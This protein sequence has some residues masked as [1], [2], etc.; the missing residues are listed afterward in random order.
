MSKRTNYNSIREW[1][2]SMCAI[3]VFV[4]IGLIIN[5]KDSDFIP[6]NAHLSANYI[7]TTKG[8]ENQEQIRFIDTLHN[9]ITNETIQ[10]NPYH[11]R[12]VKLLLQELRTRN[13]TKWNSQQ[14]DHRFH[15]QYKFC[16]NSTRSHKLVVIR[17]KSLD[18]HLYYDSNIT[19]KI[20]GYSRNYVTCLKQ[21]FAKYGKQIPNIDVMVQTTDFNSKEYIFDY[22]QFPC[23]I[24]KGAYNHETSNIALHTIPISI[25]KTF[26]SDK[27]LFTEYHDTLN[28]KNK[29]NSAVFRGSPFFGL[30]GMRDRVVF[31]VNNNLS[32]NESEYFDAKLVNYPNSR[33]AKTPRFCGDGKEMKHDCWVRKEDVMTYEDELKYRYHII[34]DGLT[35]R[36]AF[37]RQMYY[38]TV[39]LKE[40]TIKKEFWYYDLVDK[41]DIFLFD[42]ET[43]LVDIMRGLQDGTIMSLDEQMKMANGLYNYAVTHF[44]E[45]SLDCFMVNMFKIYNHFFYDSRSVEITA[46][47]VHINVSS[48][49]L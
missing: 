31:H 4:K 12:Y 35:T 34:I 48:N 26:D 19:D 24:T 22:N 25:L 10:C 30:N 15:H 6:L 16:T 7:N 36:D 8:S 2:I 40:N 49:T 39:M 38:D 47:D 17:I 42:N 23:F 14:F 37:A 18:G 13:M 44:D 46:S 41:H 3:W 1:L 33:Q 28:W 32:R 29:T 5:Y 45:D 21:L 20:R 9:Q 11:Y 43:H 27:P